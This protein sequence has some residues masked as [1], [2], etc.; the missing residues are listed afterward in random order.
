M[1]KSFLS[2]FYHFDN[3]LT[4]QEYNIQPMAKQEIYTREQV[5]PLTWM[6]VRFIIPRILFALLYAFT[7][8]ADTFKSLDTN[9][10]R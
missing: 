10:P 4:K 7:Q 6:F 2:D 3:T 1:L 9:I 5:Y 8:F